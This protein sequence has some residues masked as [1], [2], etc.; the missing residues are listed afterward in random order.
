MYLQGEPNAISDPLQRQSWKLTFSVL[1][2]LRP[3]LFTTATFPSAPAVPS[4][5]APSSVGP[6]GLP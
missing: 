3:R 1:Q 5:V 2:L 6:P 4:E